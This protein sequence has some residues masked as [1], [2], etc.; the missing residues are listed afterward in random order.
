VGAG[1][2]T[3]VQTLLAD[4]ELPPVLAAQVLSTQLEADE[5]LRAVAMAFH[6]PV[7]NQGKAALLN[8][9][10]RFLAAQ[11]GRDRRVL[12]VVDEAQNLSPAAVEELRMLSN[13]QAGHRAVMQSF[14]VGQ[15]QLRGLLASPHLEQFRQRVIASCHLGPIAAA[16]VEAY[17]LHRLRK[18]GWTERPRLHPGVFARIHGWTDGIPRRVNLL[19]TRLLLWCFLSGAEEI[20]PADADT[21]ARE[22]NAE[23]APLQSVGGGA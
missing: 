5:L 11:A 4:A 13:F 18:V 22:M 21:V 19:C 2:T 10:A 8:A 20:Q 12:L 3:L 16:E 1:K 23:L 6:L 14:L 7:E 15:P 9:M 17:V